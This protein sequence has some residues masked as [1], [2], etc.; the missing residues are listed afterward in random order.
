MKL[1]EKLLY[2]SILFIFVY[3]VLSITLRMFHF[4]EDYTSHMI[5]G[6]A[7]TVLSVLLFMYLLMKKQ[8]K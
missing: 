3:V 7:A 4:T 5:G 6:I 1:L 8:K 2:S